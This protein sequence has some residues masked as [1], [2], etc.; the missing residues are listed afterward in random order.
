MKPFKTPERYME[1]IGSELT[2]Q[3]LASSNDVSLVVDEQGVVQDVGFGDHS[4]LA[5]D[6]DALR[7]KDWL[8]TV[9]SESRTKIHDLLAITAETAPSRWRQVN[10]PGDGDNDIPVLYRVLTRDDEG[11]LI[12]VGRDLRPTFELQQQLLDVQHSMERDYARLHQAETRYRMLF[13][14]AAE[15]ILIVDANSRRIV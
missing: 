3:L 14:L 7:G 2:G 8:E 4:T 5:G 11:N 1:G 6:L 12:A 9:T 10:H 15:G 13:T